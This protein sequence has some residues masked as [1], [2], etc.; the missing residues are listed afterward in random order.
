MPTVKPSIRVP[1]SRA[2][3]AFANA[4]VEHGARLDRREKDWLVI[5]TQ[6]DNAELVIPRE[7]FDAHLPAG[8][9]APDADDAWFSLILYRIGQVLEF[10]T[11]LIVIGPDPAPLYS[12]V[13]PVTTNIRFYDPAVKDDAERLAATTGFRSLNA[14]LQEAVRQYNEFWAART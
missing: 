10:A 4:L 1:F 7:V 11:D 14:Y 5:T 6:E 2:N 3:I 13:E 9:A 8:I 12:G